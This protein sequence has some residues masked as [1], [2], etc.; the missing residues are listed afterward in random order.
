MFDPATGAPLGIFFPGSEP[1]GIAFDGDG[2]FYAVPV[3]DGDRIDIYP[4]GTLPGAPVPGVL[5]A[6]GLG[7]DLEGLRFTC[8]GDPFLA[9]DA[10]GGAVQQVVAPGGPHVAWTSDD[11]PLDIAQDPCTGDIL[12]TVRAAGRIARLTAP[13]SASTFA[14]GLLEPYALAFDESG[15]LYVT[16]FGGN[17]LLKFSTPSPCAG[18]CRCPLAPCAVGGL[19]RPGTLLGAKSG[20]AAVFSWLSDPGA[21]EYHLNTVVLKGALPEPGPHRPPVAGS[22][23]VGQCEAIAPAVTCTDPNAIPDLVP[24]LFYQVLSACGPS[25][26]EE[27]PAD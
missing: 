10:F 26:S 27:G 7:N 15:N 14:S 4:A 5:W 3:R 11:H 2:N 16:E 9:A 1:T 13:G 17:R 23:G 21:A 18:R 12:V 24:L 6:S 8:D 25:G 22:V 19:D 20:A